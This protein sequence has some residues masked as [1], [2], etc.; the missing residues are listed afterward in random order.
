MSARQPPIRW[1][2]ATV[3][4]K[5]L[6]TPYVMTLVLNVPH[7]PGHKAGQHVDLRLTADDGYQAQRSYSIASASD[8][9]T[10]AIT[11]ERVA[12]GEVSSFLL[13][14]V[15]I[16]DDLE[17]RGPIGGYFVWSPEDRRP[18]LLIG[19]GSGVVPLM[20]ILRARAKAQ[21]R[22]TA[23]LLY[24]SREQDAIIYRHE[25][26]RMAAGDDG[27]EILYTLTRRQPSGWAGAS[28]RID[29]SMLEGF[30]FSPD[31]DPIAF[32]CGP[33]AF[34]EEVAANLLAI[35][36]RNDMV[37]TERFGPTGADE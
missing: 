4:A 29:R 37:R 19:G 3:I 6:E 11:V 10:V 2:I 33:T 9:G 26:D 31:D 23:H 27:I 1:L 18:L 12:D 36:Y 14:E 30:G 22:P 35:G 28:R 16:A 5:Q 24:S 15:R 13:D 17:L 7:W 21:E 20:S 34:V 8:G 25:L 32:V